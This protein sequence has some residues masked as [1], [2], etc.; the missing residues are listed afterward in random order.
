METSKLERFNHWW[1]NK[2]VD[3]ELALPFKRDVYLKIGGYLKDRFIIALVGLRRVGK[4]TI[5]YQLIQKLIVEGVKVENIFFFSFDDVAAKL[6]DAIETYKEMQQRNF[7]EERIYVFLDEIQKCNNWENEIKKYYDIYPKLKFIISGS[8]S[9]FIRK[10]TK[11]TLAGRIF[12][13]MLGTFTFEE[14]LKLS[15]VKRD[16]F[17]YETKVRP[18]F[19]RFAERGGFPETF[20]FERET[21]FKEY[22]RTLVV[23]RII[24]KDIP[25]SFK[26]E[27]PE[28][29]GTLL[30]L[31]A[32][33]PGMYIDYQS[34]S[35]QFGKDRRVIKDYIFYLKESFL[36]TLLGNYR[37][38]SITTLRKKKRA[39]PTDNA[40]IYL[41]KPKIDE[42]F[43]G[44]MIET[45]IVNKVKAAAFWKNG[46][47]VDII[48]ENMPI[49]VKYQEK[50]NAED[51]KPLREFMR[52]FGKREGMIIT[53]HEE[54][55]IDVE[56]GRI[57]L[58]PILKWLLLDAEPK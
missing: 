46:N 54:K 12:E 38:G 58:I 23:D 22:I 50:I 9:L 5:M 53:K 18:F 32:T 57:K 24:Y 31:I 51:F 13:F 37:K 40:L 4:T 41:Y 36:I 49:E 3:P 10:K 55:Q 16:E 30:E 1:I 42:T 20:S 6:D 15:G 35:R 39:Y 19:L 48:Y 34:L 2:E 29:L 52:K 7:R 33:N 45:I 17:K 8:E 44:R 27:D 26:I 28:F 43:F 56:E 11:E 25:K 47:E 14:Y 21:D